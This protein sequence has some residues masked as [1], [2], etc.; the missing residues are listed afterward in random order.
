MSCGCCLEACPQYTEGGDFIGAAAIGQ[1]RYF[2]RQPVA[3]QD[4]EQRLDVMMEPDGIEQCGNAQ[5]CVKVCPKN[6][7]LLEAIAEVNRETN[8]HAIRSFFGV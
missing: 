2:N 1:V 7:N 8:K 4:A 3:A 6:V 5:N